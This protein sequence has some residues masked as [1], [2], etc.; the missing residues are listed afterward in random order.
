MLTVPLGPVDTL[1]QTFAFPTLIELVMVSFVAISPLAPALLGSY[2]PLVLLFE[3]VE[4]KLSVLKLLPFRSIVE[5][6]AMA[7]VKRKFCVV[8]AFTPRPSLGGGAFTAVANI[9]L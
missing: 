6:A 3:S 2:L 4:S 8:T 5:L 1:P 7:L 9:E